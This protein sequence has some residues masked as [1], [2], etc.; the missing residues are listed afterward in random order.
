[1]SQVASVPTV[2]ILDDDLGFVWWL[3]EI[4]TEL[5]YAPSCPQALSTIEA[6]DLSVD[7]A[8]LNPELPGIS[9]MIRAIEHAHP[10]KIVM[11]GEPTPEAM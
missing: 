4:F 2:L 6:L 3:G 5:G 8:I 1:V 7:L 11:I 9:P 10:A